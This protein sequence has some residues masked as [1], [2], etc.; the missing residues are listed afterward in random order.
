MMIIHRS[1]L[2][3]RELPGLLVILLIGAVSSRRRAHLRRGESAIRSW[4]A[5]PGHHTASVCDGPPGYLH[6]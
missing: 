2:E 4:N 6:L 1:A 3:F 5:L